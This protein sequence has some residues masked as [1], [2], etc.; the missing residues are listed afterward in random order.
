MESVF[1]HRESLATILLAQ[2]NLN[3]IIYA[4]ET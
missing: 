1:A 4:I 3:Q 2:S